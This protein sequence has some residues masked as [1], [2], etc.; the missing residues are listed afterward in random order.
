MADL[1]FRAVV[2]AHIARRWNAIALQSAVDDN[3][4]AEW[5]GEEDG[6]VSSSPRGW[7][8]T[9]AEAIADLVEQLEERA[10]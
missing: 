9:E 3:Y 5:A 1:M 8:K 10:S 7:G 4:D 6:Y 2:P